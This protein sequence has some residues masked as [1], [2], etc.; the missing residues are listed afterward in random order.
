ML[1]ETS[2]GASVVKQCRFILFIGRECTHTYSDR[3]SR[4]PNDLA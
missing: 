3:G 2:V 1:S 4:Q